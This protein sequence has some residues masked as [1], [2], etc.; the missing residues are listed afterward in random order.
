M[1]AIFQ[2][3]IIKVKSPAWIFVR[4]V[5]PLFCLVDVQR[6]QGAVACRKR[7]AAW[8]VSRLQQEQRLASK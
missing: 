4:A 6:R 1:G 3:E 8:W 2:S 7:C 5:S